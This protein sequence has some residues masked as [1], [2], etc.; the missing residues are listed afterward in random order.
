MGGRKTHGSVVIFIG[1][2]LF[3]SLLACS[4]SRSASPY[5][6]A[7]I[8]Y[9]DGG[10]NQERNALA[11]YGIRRVEAELGVEVDMFLP[12]GG[13][14]AD[15]FAREEGEGETPYHYDLVV[16]LGQDSSMDM[17]SVRPEDS[18][19]PSAALDFEQPQPVPGEDQVALV[20]YRVEEG[21]YIC[22]FAAG[23]LSSTS[24]HPLA[25]PLPVVAFIGALDDPLTPYYAA[26]FS[27]GVVAAAPEGGSYDYF[28]PSAGDLETARAYAEDAVSKGAD[29]IFCTPGAFNQEVMRVAEE[30]DALVILVG[31]DRSEE[32]PDHVLTSLI[33]RDDNAFFVAVERALD[34]DMEAGRQ[35]WGIEEGVWSLA[36]FHGHDPYIKRELKEAIQEQQESVSSIDFSS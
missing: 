1:V 8:G 5:R 26:G 32:S 9:G 7:L 4:C 35:V 20:R 30:K 2:L 3:L 10:M 36:P 33:L 21:S 14:L 29:I 27:K 18:T 19:L 22:G 23:W 11:E 17:L 15:L 6:V 28:I 25:N 13:N 34:D 16:S 24:D 12:G 31:F